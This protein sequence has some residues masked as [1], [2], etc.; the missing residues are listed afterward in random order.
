MSS[1]DAVSS[2]IASIYLPDSHPWSIMSISPLLPVVSSRTPSHDVCMLN[3]LL[4]GEGDIWAANYYVLS[5]SIPLMTPS[6]S[7][8]ISGQDWEGEKEK[9][10]FMN[11]ERNAEHVINYPLCY[12]TCH[13]ELWFKEL[14]FNLDATILHRKLSVLYL[15]TWCWA[16]LRLNQPHER[17]S[18]LTSSHGPTKNVLVFIT[19]ALIKAINYCNNCIFY[20]NSDQIYLV[21]TSHHHK[22][23]FL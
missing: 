22:S 20:D 10:S 19:A 7:L 18:Y 1:I 5:C 16:T 4:I 3:R 11:P 14:T 8:N 23:A 15:L 17:I 13:L 9:A 6:R 2:K 12:Q 21:K